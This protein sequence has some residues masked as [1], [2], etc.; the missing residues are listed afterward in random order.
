MP[1]ERNERQMLAARKPKF[2]DPRPLPPSPASVGPPAVS[3]VD[4]RLRR[5]CGRYLLIIVVMLLLAATQS[6]LIVSRNYELARMKLQVTELEKTIPVLRAELAR[7]KS[8]GNVQRLAVERLKMVR[9]QDVLVGTVAGNVKK[10][11]DGDPFTS[12]GVH[13][14]GLEQ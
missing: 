13:A 2:V 3:L 4:L 6:Q 5:R 8:P 10:P 1:K 7:L 12:P 11:A 9:A 14:Q